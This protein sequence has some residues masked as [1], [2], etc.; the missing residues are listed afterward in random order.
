MLISFPVGLLLLLAGGELLARANKSMIGQK[1][2]ALNVNYLGAEPDL[3]GKP[4]IVEFW[5][6]W[7]PPCRE[8]IPHL[9]EV[10]GKY[11]ERGLEIVGISNESREK[12]EAFA[13]SVPFLYHVALDPT[14]AIGNQLQVT[15]IPHAVLISRDGVVVWEGH[16]LQ[17]KDSDI[18]IVLKAEKSSSPARATGESDVNARDER[19]WTPL[20]HAATKGDADAIRDLMGRGAQ[21]NAQDDKGWTPLMLAAHKGHDSAVRALIIKGANPNIKTGKGTTALMVAAGKGHT[22][23][24]EILLDAGADRQAKDADGKTALDYATEKGSA[25]TIQLLQK[26]AAAN[27]PSKSAAKPSGPAAQTAATAPKPTPKVEPA[28][29]SPQPAKTVTPATSTTSNPTL[30]R[31]LSMSEMKQ[32]STILAGALMTYLFVLL[33]L[34]IFVCY[35]LKRICAKAERPS[36]LLVWIPGLQIIPM[37]RAADISYWS[38]LLLFIPIVNV[39]Y[40]FWIYARLCQAVGKSPWLVVLVIIPGGILILLPYLAFSSTE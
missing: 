6:T 10:Y 12:V 24:V 17:L 31:S 7:C 34:Y 35:C 20:M 18:E 21:V 16:P 15:G 37:L 38:L 40:F 26:T 29:S 8:S 22:D 13:K 32:L 3:N 5:A 14:G 33:G 39:I 1:F 25:T 4:M 27:T 36:V 2:P 11:K 9:N 30:A 28:P 19:Q 23:A